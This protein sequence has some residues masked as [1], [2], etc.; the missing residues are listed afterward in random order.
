MGTLSKDC[1][2]RSSLLTVF[3]L[4][5]GYTVGFALKGVTD[6]VLPK[7]PVQKL[8]C[9]T[10]LTLLTFL[11]QGSRRTTPDTAED[12]VSDRRGYQRYDGHKFDSR[13]RRGG[14]DRRRNHDDEETVLDSQDL[15]S[16]DIGTF[17]NYPFKMHVKII[18]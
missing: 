1:L 9:Q 13:N 4:T 15:S 8:N 10:G 7:T 2:F 12:R 18:Y 17:R 11:V 16:V 6:C 14:D 3:Q 5:L